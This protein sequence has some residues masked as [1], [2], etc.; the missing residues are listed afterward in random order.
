MVLKDRVAIVTGG[1]S[2]IGR[3]ICLE[4]AREGACVVVADVQETPKRG[5]YHEKDITTPTAVEIENTGGRA[6][7]VECDVS[8]EASVHHLIDR[9]VAHFGKLDI[10]VNNAGIFKPGDSQS[11]VMADWDRI[12]GVNLRALFLTMKYAIPHLKKSKTGRIVNIAS[13]HAFHGGGGP[14]YAPAKAG[15]VN[16]T[17][18]IAMELGSH[19]ITANTVCPGYIETPIQDYLTEADIQHC[20]DKT[21][22]P[23]LGKPRDIG[24]ACVFLASDDAEW[25]TG[26]ALPVDGGWL[27]PIGIL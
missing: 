13:V 17:R 15:V 6:L 16:M 24:R 1:S 9:A 8:E 14:A 27:A 22:L 26:V 5:K 3:G 25:I 7:F 11:L 23:R 4:F 21:P 18:D 19:G 10:L 12:V 2:G 20:L